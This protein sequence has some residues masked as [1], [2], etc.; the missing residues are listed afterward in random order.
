MNYVPFKHASI[1]ALV[2]ALFAAQAA[3]AQ[4]LAPANPQPPIPGTTF[5]LSNGRSITPLSPLTVL[6]NYIN[7]PPTCP[8]GVPANS[9]APFVSGNQVLFFLPVSG[10][11]VVPTSFFT[12]MPIANPT[13]LSNMPTTAQGQAAL[14]PITTSENIGHHGLPNEGQVMAA[15]AFFGISAGFESINWNKQDTDEMLTELHDRDF[16]QQIREREKR[17]QEQ[18]ERDKPAVGEVTS[19]GSGLDIPT[20]SVPNAIQQSDASAASRTF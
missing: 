6:A 5:N 15:M 13:A 9:V 20:I 17:E 14:A 1:A 7:C 16:L 18:R 19:E 4:S 8:P 2:C 3:Q 10:S 11:V 12:S